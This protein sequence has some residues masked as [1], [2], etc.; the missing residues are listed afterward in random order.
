M[1][2]PVGRVQVLS[3]LSLGQRT[4]GLPLQHDELCVL[5]HQFLRFASGQ[6]HGCTHLVSVWRP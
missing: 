4:R 3:P 6:V 5:Q 1:N 2:S